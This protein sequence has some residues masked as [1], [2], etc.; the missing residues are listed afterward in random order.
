MGSKSHVA[1]FK[2]VQSKFSDKKANIYDF[3][4]QWNYRV[5]KILGKA[6]L[7]MGDASK[8]FK[9][10]ENNPYIDLLTEVQGGTKTW[11]TKNNTPYGANPFQT[12]THSTTATVGINFGTQAQT[13]GGRYYKNMRGMGTRDPFEKHRKKHFEDQNNFVDFETV[14]FLGNTAAKITTKEL[15]KDLDIVERVGTTTKVGHNPYG[16]QQ[17][18]TSYKNVTHKVGSEGYDAAWQRA[19]EREFGGTKSGDAKAAKAEAAAK[20]SRGGIFG[21]DAYRNSHQQKLRDQ[22]RAK[23]PE[24]TFTFAGLQ[25]GEDNWTT[26]SKTGRVLNDAFIDDEFYGKLDDSHKQVFGLTVDEAIKADP[27][28][29]AANQVMGAA[30]QGF[31]GWKDAKKGGGF[32]KKAF[33]VVA[34]ILGNFIVPGIGGVIGGAIGSAVGGGD[35]GDVLKGAA[36][37]GLGS[38]GKIG[39]LG[40]I[41]GKAGTAALGGAIGSALQGGDL[42]DILAGGLTGYAGGTGGWQG[43]IANAGSTAL[44]GGD[45]KD[46]LASGFGSFAGKKLGDFS[47]GKSGSIWGSQG[48]GA[49]GNAGPVQLT[50]AVA[51]GGSNMSLWDTLKGGVSSLFGNKDGNWDLSSILK[52]GGDILLGG[53]KNSGI[54]GQVISGAGKYYLDKKQSDVQRK[55]I[56][57]ATAKA[58]N[59]ADPF[60]GY[61]GH[62]GNEL[63]NLMANPDSIQNSSA[64][65]FRFDQGMEGLSRQMNKSG[66]RLSG[67]AVTEAIN[68]GQGAA[69]QEFNNQFNRL[70][71]LSGATSGNLGQAASHVYDGGFAA[72]T[73][74][75]S[76]YTT[77]QQILSGVNR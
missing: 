77:L 10:Y 76:K 7:N 34:P 60:A 73:S 56:E 61:R 27:V 52:T 21:Q 64:Y 33:S 31:K 20:R 71:N 29:S 57:D 59:T 45:L 28:L 48:G 9:A 30:K 43:A 72:G 54:L 74:K 42:K 46:V 5:K 22:H 67:N 44:S 62:Y 23:S 11:Q 14:D 24:A 39:N 51:Q 3:D 25:E 15:R 19:N 75:A 12:K 49:A 38:I 53:G 63:N 69:S 47:F 8:L 36:L 41:L 37:G 17:F 4:N 70:G 35:L 65:Q 1:T 50:N 40:N 16:P 2:T 26:V 58:A 6:G 68:Y 66:L 32:F 13:Y 55:A 18:K